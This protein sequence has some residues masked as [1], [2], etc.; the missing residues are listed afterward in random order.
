MD[1]MKRRA[2]TLVELLV[3][4]AIIALLVSIL[5][6]ALG[7]ARESAKQS[8]CLS[9]QRTLGQAWFAYAMDNRNIVFGGTTRVVQIGERELA[10]Q[11]SVYHPEESWVATPQYDGTNGYPQDWSEELW[12][13]CI[14]IGT[15]YPYVETVKVYR[16]PTKNKTVKGAYI[17][18]TRSYSISSSLYGTPYIGGGQEA[19]EREK[20]TVKSLGAIK[21]PAARMALICQGVVTQENWGAESWNPM[22]LGGWQ[23]VPPVNHG[24]GTTMSFADGHA[25]FHRW[26]TEYGSNFNY[27]SGISLDDP[28]LVWAKRAVWGD[29]P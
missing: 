9:N 22:F 12:N 2:F 3:V 16:C 13:L 19:L 23:D 5:L 28:D 26:E 18:E 15:L 17:D 7:K 4:V 25:E 6:P 8:M 24:N 20:R 14:E 10:W 21:M 27:Y 29:L 1:K 11:F